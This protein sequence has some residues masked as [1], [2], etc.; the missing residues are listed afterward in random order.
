MQRNELVSRIL[1]AVSAFVFAGGGI[2]HALAASK[3]FS[4]IDASNLAP[5]LGKELKMLWLADST[6]LVVVALIC[7][8][9]AFRPTAAARSITMLVALV[10]GA[11]AVLLYTFL[12]GFYAGHLLM[13]TSALVLVAALL[14][15][16]RPA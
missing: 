13:V 15:R 16:D 10:P 11:T 7:G 6:T 3:A 9:L 4:S 5:F 1:L 8:T 12:G 14:G 2:L